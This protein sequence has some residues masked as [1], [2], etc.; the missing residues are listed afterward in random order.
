MGRK[1][2]IRRLAKYLP[3]SI[4][5][6][7]AAALDGMAE[8]GQ[9][10]QLNTIDGEFVLQPDDAPQFEEGDPEGGQESEATRGR[11]TEQAPVTVPQSASGFKAKEA[12][13]AGDPNSWTPSPEEQAEI[14]AREKA[15]AQ[16]QSGG[17]RRGRG[18]S[19]P[20]DGFPDMD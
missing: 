4:E 10:Q 20:Q 19:A 12:Q 2:V 17:G 5:F 13:P 11:L 8:A 16:Q 7:T 6:Q 1:T 3:L 9:D 15:E 14:E 18:R